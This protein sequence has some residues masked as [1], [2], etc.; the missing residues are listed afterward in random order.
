M[1][2]EESARAVPGLGTRSTAGGVMGSGRSFQIGL[3]SRLD[4]DALQRQRDRERR[5]GSGSLVTVTPPPVIWKNC[6]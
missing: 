3:P 1:R 2:T 5:A 6:G 4:R